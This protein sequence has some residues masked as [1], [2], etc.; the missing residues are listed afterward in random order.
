[1]FW[2]IVTIILFKLLPYLLTVF[3]QLY[4]FFLLVFY[5]W[6]YNRAGELFLTIKKHK[7][8]QLL[9][10]GLGAYLFV[11][12]GN[13]CSLD[14]IWVAEIADSLISISLFLWLRLF[15]PIEFREKGVVILGYLVRW[16]KICRYKWQSDRLLLEHKTWFGDRKTKIRVNRQ[17]QL[18]VE[19]I[20]R[21]KLTV[22]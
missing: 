1:M 17:Q 7:Y 3:L 12:G 21:K 15:Y 18:Q 4:C 22:V 19:F 16:S 20:L 13:I 11:L 6:L 5:P 9:F 8:R 14:N 10:V 2:T